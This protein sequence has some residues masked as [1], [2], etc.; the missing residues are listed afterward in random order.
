MRI[1]HLKESALKELRQLKALVSDHLSV[2][3][4]SNNSGLFEQGNDGLDK[5]LSASICLPT[6]EM[7]M[8]LLSATQKRN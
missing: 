3:E 1:I 5:S 7:S 6:P 4:N 2:I 8:N